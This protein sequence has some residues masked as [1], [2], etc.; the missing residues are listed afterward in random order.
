MKKVLRMLRTMNVILSIVGCSL[1]M[2]ALIVACGYRMQAADY[3]TLTNLAPNCALNM[4][5]LADAGPAFAQERSTDRVCT[6]G[7]RAILARAG[8]ILPD[9]GKL[10]CP[11]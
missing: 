10:G 3:A 7:A 5:L 4:Q 8:Q 11:Q 2:S 9:A 6:C 1:A